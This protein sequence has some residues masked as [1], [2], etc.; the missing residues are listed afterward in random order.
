MAV[1]C[2]LSCKN[3]N[4]QVELHL[5]D[6]LMDMS[7]VDFSKCAAV[8]KMAITEFTL[9]VTNIVVPMLNQLKCVSM[10]K[11]GKHYFQQ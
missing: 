10:E 6:C 2:V 1:K 11:S 7:S 9:Y 4:Q 3:I 8:L 5:S